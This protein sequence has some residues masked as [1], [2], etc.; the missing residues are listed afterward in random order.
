M[1][2]LHLLRHAKS[3]WKQPLL[4]D[5]QRPLK[6]RGRADAR[7]VAQ[8]MTA[9]GWSAEHVFCSSAQ[10]A[11]Q[12]IAEVLAALDVDAGGVSYHEALYTFDH[13]SLLGWLVS[14]DEEVLTI[15]GHNPA[16]HELVEWFAA[17]TLEKFPTAA[18]CRLEVDVD[19]WREFSRGSGHI[20]QL[21]FPKQLRPV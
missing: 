10:R 5:E 6:K 16:L 21:V 12:T 11:R 1:K 15:V 14:R 8:A 19:N 7:L 3:S 2:T 4:D 18:Y 17:T 20:T 13:R 9:S